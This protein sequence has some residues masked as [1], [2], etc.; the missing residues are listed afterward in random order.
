MNDPDVSP[1]ELKLQKLDRRDRAVRIIEVVIL[2]AFG[3]FSTLTNVRLQHVIDSNNAATVQARK[4]NIERQEQ[5]QNYIKC[6]VLLKFSQP[7]LDPNSRKS[8]EAAL[9]KCAKTVN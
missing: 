7:P 4:D 8:V 5:S 1:A 3:A 9:D 6:I 2:L